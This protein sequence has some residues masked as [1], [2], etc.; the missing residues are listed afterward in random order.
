[1]VL[2]V[3]FKLNIIYFKELKYFWKLNISA[4][5]IYFKLFSSMHYQTNPMCVKR[6]FG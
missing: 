3:N 2:L 5:L 4:L 6:G 1:M